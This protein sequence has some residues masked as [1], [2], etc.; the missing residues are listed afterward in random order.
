MDTDGLKAIAFYP[1]STDGRT[2]N[3]FDRFS[4]DALLIGKV[5]PAESWRDDE[6]PK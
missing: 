4:A 5:V 3:S 1:E 2:S 6:Q